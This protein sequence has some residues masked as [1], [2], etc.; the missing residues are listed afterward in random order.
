MSLL[1]H[2]LCSLLHLSCALDI[3]WLNC[4]AYQFILHL[5]WVLCKYHHYSRFDS[6]DQTFCKTLNLKGF[7]RYCRNCANLFELFVVFGCIITF[8]LYF[9]SKPY[10]TNPYRL[11][12]VLPFSRGDL[13]RDSFHCVV[14]LAIPSNYHVH[15]QP[16]LIPVIGCLD[17]R[18]S[19]PRSRINT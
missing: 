17:H 7:K 2:L 12:M 9:V 4:C 14:S 18:S 15:Q 6:E 10:P 19:Q 11:K 8:V 1:L 13:R 3:R 16:A 5:L